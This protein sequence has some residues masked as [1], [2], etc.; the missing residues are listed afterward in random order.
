M[1]RI[2]IIA[3]AAVLSTTMARAAHIWEDAGGWWDDHF[4]YGNSAGKP[5]F[6]SGELSLDLFGSYI[7]PERAIEDLFETNIRKG[8]WGGGVGL[9]YFVTREIGIGGDINISENGGQFVDQALGSLILRLPWERTGVA[10][11]IL[12]GGGRA[13]D[14]DGEWLGH[15]G[16]GLELRFNPVTGIFADGRYIWAEH[17]SDRLLLRA[18]FRIVF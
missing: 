10:P 4:Q 12:G 15:A 5:K 16:G 8:K 7:N 18:G 6:A 17:T 11:Y 9:N 2:I 13:F 1:K 3:I 14:P